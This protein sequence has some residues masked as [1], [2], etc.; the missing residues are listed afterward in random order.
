[1]GSFVIPLFQSKKSC[2]ANVTTTPFLHVCICL[3]HKKELNLSI[4]Q[5]A[6]DDRKEN[7]P[8]LDMIISQFCRIQILVFVWLLLLSIIFHY[9]YSTIIFMIKS[10]PHF[11]YVHTTPIQYNLAVYFYV[12]DKIGIENKWS[13]SVMWLAYA[14]LCSGML[15]KLRK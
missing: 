7:S 1:M 8:F 6:S 10:K 2:I 15:P 12:C 13:A 9:T 3:L 11:V 14:F 5:F 4:V